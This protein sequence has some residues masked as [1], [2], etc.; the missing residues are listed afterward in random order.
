MFFFYYLSKYYLVSEKI[1]KEKLNNN[2]NMG[3]KYA[4]L[5]MLNKLQITN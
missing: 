3:V 2:G 1:Q 4:S 5:D